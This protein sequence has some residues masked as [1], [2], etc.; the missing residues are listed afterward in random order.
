MGGEEGGEEGEGEGRGQGRGKGRGKGAR[1]RFR[2]SGSGRAGA[3]LGIEHAA[4]EALVGAVGLAHHQRHQLLVP[5]VQPAAGPQHLGHLVQAVAQLLARLRI[6]RVGGRINLNLSAGP[7]PGPE[8]AESLRLRTAPS[9]PNRCDFA[10]PRVRRI[11]A[12]SHRMA[13]CRPAGQRAQ[14]RRRGE[15]KGGRGSARKG[16]GVG[17]VGAL[18][19]SGGEGLG[20]ERRTEEGVWREGL[21]RG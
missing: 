15:G 9:L 17:L 18:W 7:G 2:G 12:T 8:Y 11:A 10:Q 5:V 19:E 6:F 14:R 21:G 20:T 4:D 3:G 16:D 1:S 13:D